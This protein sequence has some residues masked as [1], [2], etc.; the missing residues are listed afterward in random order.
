MAVIEKGHSL[1]SSFV[2]LLK[3]T[4]LAGVGTGLVATL[5]ST[6]G[7]GVIVMTSA[8][9]GG[10]TDTQAVSWLLAIYSFGGLA[11]IFGPA[12]S[13]A[14][15]RDDFKNNKSQLQALGRTQ[16]WPY[17][18]SDFEKKTGIRVMFRLVD[19]RT[20]QS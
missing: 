14:L 1:G 3:D 16:H 7:P 20:R 17:Q 18:N 6:L 11:T 2:Q 12:I 9:A 13:L 10:L 5:F 4:N 8:K 19:S 15:E